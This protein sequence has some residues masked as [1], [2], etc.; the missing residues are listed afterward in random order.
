MIDTSRTF[1]AREIAEILK[2]S[3]T[4]V[5]GLLQTREIEAPYVGTSKNG[6]PTKAY[7]FENLCE[8][9][10]FMALYDM[11]CR[12]EL[13]GAITDSYLR[14]FVEEVADNDNGL[15]CVFIL[16]QTT[17]KG[18]FY[19]VRWFGGDFQAIAECDGK[20]G[21]VVSVADIIRTIREGVS[22]GRK[23]TAA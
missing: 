3:E 5:L 14:Q 8:L 17:T 13:A 2:A 7:T 21:V 20:D 22:N 9:G 4:R 16:A 19:T 23:N 1:S 18:M 15:D 6:R 12:G 11:G 10:L